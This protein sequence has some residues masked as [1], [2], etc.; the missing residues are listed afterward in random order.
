MHTESSPVGESVPQEVELKKGE[1]MEPPGRA[2]SGSAA[3]PVDSQGLLELQEQIQTKL[4]A[5]RG[6]QE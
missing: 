1:C 2:A 6:L 3:P 5:Q 4:Q